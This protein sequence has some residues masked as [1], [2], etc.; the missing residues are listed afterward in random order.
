MNRFQHSSS[1]SASSRSGAA[2]SDPNRTVTRDHNHVHLHGASLAR[3][4]GSRHHQC[5]CERQ[6]HGRHRPH[7]HEGWRRQHHVGDGELSDQRHGI[8]GR[9]RGDRRSYPQR[10]SGSNAGVYVNVGLASGELALTNGSGSITK[11]GINVPADR[12]AA[13]LSNPAGHYFNVHTSLNPDGAI[14]GQLSGAARSSIRARRF[15]I[16]AHVLLITRPTVTRSPGPRGADELS[17]LSNLE[18][19]LTVHD[20]S[21]ALNASRTSISCGKGLDALVCGGRAESFLSRVAGLPVARTATPPSLR[22][23]EKR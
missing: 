19:H 14:R 2:D 21:P 3:Q 9:D 15:R 20:Q 13:I 17:G 1:V 6:R 16:S 7:G 11:N 10:G 5:R 22:T 18:R 12:A 8:S 4:R 23:R